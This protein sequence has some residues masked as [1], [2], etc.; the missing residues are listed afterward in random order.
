MDLLTRINR[1]AK[2]IVEM[3]L[4][5]FDERLCKIIEPNVS[6]TKERFDVLKKIRQ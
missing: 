5:T 1:N 4:T 2:C 6:T 3:T